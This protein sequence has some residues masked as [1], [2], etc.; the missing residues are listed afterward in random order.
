MRESKLDMFC[1]WLTRDGIAF[2]RTPTTHDELCHCDTT[3]VMVTAPDGGFVQVIFNHRLPRKGYRQSENITAQRVYPWGSRS[4]ITRIE[5]AST[6][7]RL[8]LGKL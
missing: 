7:V 6:A 8:M 3:E 4:R 2:T 1:R 5:R